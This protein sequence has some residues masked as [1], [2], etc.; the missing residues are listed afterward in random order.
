MNEVDLTKLFVEYAQTKAHLV[1]LEVVIKQ[2]VF[3]RKSTVKIAGISAKYYNPSE[4]TPDYEGSVAA[5][6][7]SHPLFDR[8]YLDEF[9]ETKVS[10]AWKDICK[11]FDITVIPGEPKPARVVLS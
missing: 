9:S 11:R 2:E 1:E 3:L 7:G 10:F 8:H 5:Y 4:G 6:L